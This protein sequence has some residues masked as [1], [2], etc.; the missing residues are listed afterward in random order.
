MNDNNIIDCYNDNND[1]GFKEEIIYVWSTWITEHASHTWF[2]LKC[3]FLDSRC[4]PVRQWRSQWWGEN[5]TRWFSMCSIKKSRTRPHWQIKRLTHDYIINFSHFIMWTK[6][7]KLQ[8]L[9][10]VRMR[11]R[12]V[13]LQLESSRVIITFHATWQLANASAHMRV[14]YHIYIHIIYI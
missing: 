12:V 8:K 3:A 5:Q 10:W 6:K 2:N 9:K 4:S 11:E 14:Y 1:N 7:K 13:C